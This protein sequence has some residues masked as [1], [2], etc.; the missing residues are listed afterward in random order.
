MCSGT[1]A[2]C[3]CCRTA[4]TA[5]HCVPWVAVPHRLTE[6][7][8]AAVV[9]VQGARRRGAA[10][11][12]RRAQ[13]VL[14]HLL[15]VQLLQPP[16]SSAACS[17]GVVRYGCRASPCSTCTSGCSRQLSTCCNDGRN[18]RT[19]CSRGIA[20]SA[21]GMQLP[22]PVLAGALRLHAAWRP[23]H[24]PLRGLWALKHGRGDKQRPA[25]SCSSSPGKTIAVAACALADGQVPTRQ[26]RHCLLAI[27]HTGPT[28]LVAPVSTW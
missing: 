7:N 10:V 28:V 12:P 13:A 20:H 9:A 25:S 6:N 3:C 22:S 1:P 4:P 15:R 2:R 24:P 5:V 11:Q 8:P 21:M 14:R 16:V 18:W 27:P 26:Q 17:S 19:A 23:P